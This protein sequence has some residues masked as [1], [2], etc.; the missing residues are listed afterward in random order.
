M[1]QTPITPTAPRGLKRYS[2]VPLVAGLSVAAV[3]VSVMILSLEKPDSN[4]ETPQ[5]KNVENEIAQ[6]NKNNKQSRWF[7]NRSISTLPDAN[8]AQSLG[9]LEPAA[10]SAENLD[11]SNAVPSE[12]DIKAQDE[13]RKAQLEVIRFEARQPLSR[14]KLQQDGVRAPLRVINAKDDKTGN[15]HQP[16]NSR[17]SLSDARMV[18]FG[19]GQQLAA[20]YGDPEDSYS[21]Q[22]DQAG[23]SDFLTAME[24]GASDHYLHDTLHPPVSPYEV[25]AGTVIPAALIT[26]INS[27]LPGAITAQVR[28]NVYD[29]VSGEYLLIPQGARLIGQYDSHIS[30]GQDRALVVWNRLIMPDGESI[31]LGKMQ[32][33]DIAGYAGFNDLVDNHYLRIYGNAL[34]MSLVGSGYELLANPSGNSNDDNDPQ[35]TIAANIGLQLAQVTAQITR[36]NINIQPTIEIR[37]GYR[38]NVMVLKDMVLKAR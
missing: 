22:N 36:K 15:P 34:L 23:K 25:K 20:L 2:A 16:A 21:G 5:Q 10:G 37:Q 7:D 24:A 9:A 14:L 32:G 1:A 8:S 6:L 31:D 30:F 29:T 18:R 11:E 35:D 26:G 38:F 3:I 19:N 13:R 28:E 4:A 27:N 12:F 33:V 17:Q